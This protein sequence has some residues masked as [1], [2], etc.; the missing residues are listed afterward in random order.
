MTY[1]SIFPEKKNCNVTL[2]S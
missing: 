2:H 1:L